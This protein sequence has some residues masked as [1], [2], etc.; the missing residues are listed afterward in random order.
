M[1]P[2]D[3]LAFQA[4]EAVLQ[5]E[6]RNYGVVYRA[7]RAR[8]QSTLSPHDYY[9]SSLSRKKRKELQRQFNRLQELG[10]VAICRRS[11]ASQIE[12]WVSDFL[13][14]EATGWKG[15][16]GSALASNPATQRLFQRAL[17]GASQQGRLERLSLTLD[18][19]PIAML[20]T[21]QTDKVAF[22]YKTAFDE[23]YAH[24]SPDMQLQRAYLKVLTHS[25]IQWTDSCAPSGHPMIEH[26]WRESQPLAH[27][28]IAIG[29]GLRRGLFQRLLD[30][31]LSRSPPQKE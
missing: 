30:H 14:L 17:L 3:S 15:N 1:L 5:E 9:Q 12:T 16:A 27:L 22:S 7:N 19:T 4:L 24:Y 10:H 2:S 8:L 20:A 11:D 31:E 6:A 13:K 18:D 28:S 25:T 23:R 21:F 29:G 26:F